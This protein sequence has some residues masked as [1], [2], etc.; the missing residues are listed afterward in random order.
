MKKDVYIYQNS[1]I[2]QDGY[3]LSIITNQKK[4]Y[5]PI[6]QID[7]IHIFSE[8]QI[9]KRL[10]Q[11]AS[12]NNIVLFFYNYYGTYIGSYVPHTI[13]NGKIIVEQA[14]TY[15]DNYKRNSLVKKFIY[16]NI[17]NELSLIKY[18]NKKDISLSHIINQI[19]NE[20]INL[21]ELNLNSIDFVNNALLLEA[22]TKQIYFS[23]FDIILAKEKYKFQ[24]CSTQP[25]KNEVNALLS[26]GYSLMYNESLSAIIR[27]KL[28]PEISYIHSLV[29][30]G[31]SLQYNLADMLKPVIVD[32]L[33]IRLIRRK[34][35]SDNHFTE[36]KNGIYL[37]TEGKQLFVE[38]FDKVLSNSVYDSRSKRNYTYKQL[39]YR[40]VYLLIDH[41]L[42]KK[43]Y[44]PFKMRW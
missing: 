28:L 9:N 27:S 41:I 43:E 16:A 11:L 1:H 7:N 2:K 29:K 5:I 14:S 10:L 35:L 15:L 13:K 22:R 3:S 38:E 31:E 33:V 44:D 12:K 39:F 32:R 36:V 19:N 40:D 34:Q 23:S 6:E 4:V 17:T 25:P 21:K 26:Y 30:H 18:Y 8:I 37:S 20:L 42:S 24:S